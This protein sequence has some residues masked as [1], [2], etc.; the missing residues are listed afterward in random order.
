MTELT[1]R[2]LGAG[3][4]A[5]AVGAGGI[6]RLA[7]DAS[8]QADV[9]GEFDATGDEATLSEAPDAIT[10]A[11]SGQARV[12]TSGTLDQIR[13]TLQAAPGELGIDDLAETSLFDGTEG[14]YDLRADLLAD[15]REATADVFVPDRGATRTTDVRLRVVAA[16]IIDGSVAAEASAEDTIGVT[17]THEGVVVAVGG[18][19]D[20]T[21][22]PA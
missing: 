12:E 11:A 2:R 13:V 10:V 6:A 1:R 16:A 9:T 21:I 18:T 8:A 7:G 20:V 17:V 19:A 3:L 14:A 4:V 15:H 5:G 22:E